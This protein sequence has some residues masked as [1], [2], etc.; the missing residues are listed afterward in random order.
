MPFPLTFEH[1]AGSDN[2]V[3]DALSR[4]PHVQL[5][6]TTITTVA[7][8]LIGIFERIK[9]A[10]DL[11]Q[12]YGQLRQEA[13]QIDDTDQSPFSPDL[14]ELSL[15]SSSGQGGNP[16]GRRNMRRYA[17]D[18][19]TMRR[20]DSH[21]YLLRE[22]VLFTPKGQVVLPQE[23]ALRTLA[24]TEAHDD[25][26]SGHFG[27]DKTLE[28][29][30]RL[31]HWDGLPR[32]V[33]DYVQSCARCQLTKH[34]TQR[35]PGLLHPIVSKHPWHTVTLDFVGRF[36][37]AQD[38]E[39]THCLVIVDKFSKYVT[40]EGVSETVTAE[41]TAEIFLRRIV[42]NFGV[43]SVVISDRG[44]QFTALLWQKMLT[45]LGARSALAA[46]H[47][48]QSDGQT[49]RTI[50]TFLRLLR[51][52]ASEEAEQWEAML[53]LLQYAINDAYCEST[54]TTPFRLLYGRDPTSPLLT[55]FA[56]SRD[57]SEASLSL[58]E[59]AGHSDPDYPQLVAKRAA[60]IDKVWEFVRKHQTEIADRM[61][62]HYDRNRR[63][64]LLTPGDQVLVSTASHPLLRA[65]RKAK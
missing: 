65:V 46:T 2:L 49:E 30:R 48:P 44:P 61:K 14:S 54:K 52:F 16:T 20:Y 13:V 25:K 21:P 47:H 36:A 57:S 35:S 40:L 23:D 15:E 45:M 63:P 11:D 17:E 29:V 38:T 5:N 43:P 1:I 19:R 50:Q 26:I 59:A 28:K 27:Y 32:D 37:P 6:A 22:G 53:P 51:T 9:L 42:A 8:Q 4:Y 31:W 3:A 34:S 41:Q 12:N 7:P 10:G 60:Q 58:S 62:A 33:K 56:Q 64:L 39:H 18:G 55:R 24:I